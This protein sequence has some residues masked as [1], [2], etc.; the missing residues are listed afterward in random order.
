MWIRKGQYPGIAFDSVLG[1]DGAG[2][3]C[4]SRYICELHFTH[5]SWILGFVGTIVA[6]AEPQDPLLDTRVFLTPMRGWNN[7]PDAPESTSVYSNNQTP[8]GG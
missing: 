6:S 1:A 5:A 4:G 8:V 2:E 3:L 7:Y